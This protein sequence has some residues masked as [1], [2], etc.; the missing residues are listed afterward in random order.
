MIKEFNRNQLVN[1]YTLNIFSD[2]STKGSGICDVCYGAIV[3]HKENIID[4]LYRINSK[5]TVNEGEIKGI[6]TAIEFAL[7]YR[8]LFPNI[9]IFSD[10]QLSVFGIRDRIFNWTYHNIANHIYNTTGPLKN[11]SIYLEILDMIVSNGLYVNIYHQKGHVN[12]TSSNDVGVATDVFAASNNIRIKIGYDYIRYISTYNNI[13]DRE[14]RKILLRSEPRN[15]VTP[16]IYEPVDFYSKIETY[17]QI[18]QGGEQ[19]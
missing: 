5:S 12:Q 14:S 1:D 6:R 7:K 11:E 10:S 13:V 3:V 8:Y 15:I 16:I 4:R 2:A 18:K 17:K 9:N 19:Q